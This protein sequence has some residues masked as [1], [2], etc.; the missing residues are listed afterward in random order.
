LRG[1]A[2]E[3]AVGVGLIVL[4]AY[5]LPSLEARVSKPAD[6]APLPAAAR[7]A[8]DA[9]PATLDSVPRVAS[10]ELSAALD[11]AAHT[12][13]GAGV[14]RFVNTSSVAL[15]HLYVHLYLNAFAH[16]GTVFR[17]QRAG[18]FRGTTDVGTPG[19]IRVERFYARELDAELFPSEPT[20]EGDPEDATDIRVPL[21]KPLAPGAS[22]TIDTE[23]TSRLPTIALRT[24]Y[25]GSF[26]M[27]G[28][29]F[30]KLARL[31]PDGSFAHF[32]FER[33]SEFYADYGDYDVTIDVPEAFVVGATGSLESERTIDGRRLLHYTQPAVHDFAF[34]AWDG[35]VEAS[36]TAEGV[37]IRSL[38]PPGFERAQQVEIEAASRGLAE[39]G[40]RF[41]EYPY[42]T[43]TI[44]HPPSSAA[45][46]G[47]MEY[48][49]LITTGGPAWL[50]RGPVRALELLTL[51]ELGHQW[52]YGL[53]A[54]NENR[55]PF[56]D[57]GVTSWATSEA[58]RALYGPFEV[59]PLLP[60]DIASVERASAARVSSHAP[61]ATAAG[62]FA[63]GTDYG[64]LVY[65]RTATIL[66]TIDR[67][68]SG[69]AGRGIERYARENRFGHPGPEALER[70]IVAEGGDAAG[71]FFHAA[72]FE[73]GWMNVEAV[74]AQSRKLSGSSWDCEVLVRRT[75]TLVAPVEVEVTHE[76]GSRTRLEWDG[77][78]DTHRFDVE[79]SSPVIA[80]RIDPDQRL[81]LDDDEL[82][83]GWSSEPPRGA[84]RTRALSAFLAF[85]GAS[86]VLP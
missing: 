39:L 3:A 80:F 81:L 13:H 48:P 21:P 47:G 51:H 78:G 26:H 61:V 70:A 11:P 10:Y 68:W 20:T 50:A 57:E 84:P 53:V 45:E 43:L 59:S 67:V 49:T 86:L 38:A 6:S 2:I 72:V 14:I 7:P 28:Q 16:E 63:T 8:G 1:Q 71:A 44:V 32:P 54:T 83:D 65:S 52:F 18:G 33:F 23:F 55:W 36:T 85:A 15:D 76:D 62:G 82:D 24:G 40:R 4:A 66:R 34:T 19:S 79:A 77:R 29:W 22:L 64:S 17:R 69:A 46:A 12:V 35:F 37:A 56:L 27:V 30:P 41:G 58:A 73:R 75:G 31:E 74:T 60:L 42:R 5:A 25:A 9:S